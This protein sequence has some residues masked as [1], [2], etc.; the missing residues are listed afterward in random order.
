M[1][2]D[3]LFYT[4]DRSSLTDDVVALYEGNINDYVHVAIQVS[5]TQK[6][7][8]TYPKIVIDGLNERHIAH[9]YTP[10]ARSGFIESAIQSLIACVGQDYGTGDILDVL[11]HHPVFEAHTDCSDLA[12][13][14]LYWC[15]DPAILAWDVNPH[16]VTPAAL[17]YRLC[18]PNSDLVNYQ[19]EKDNEAQ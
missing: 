13:R 11:L 3:V 2:G 17:A 6:V 14:Y 1:I 9:R 12:T 19:E 7:E 18:I 15:G 5:E 8:A 4:A 10:N 16:I